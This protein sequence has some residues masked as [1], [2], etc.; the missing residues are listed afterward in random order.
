MSTLLALAERIEQSPIG[1]AIA[2]SRYAFPVIEGVH[3]IGLSISVGLIFLTDLR[4]TG[5][6]F[7]QIPVRDV[8]HHLRPY[9]VAGFAL[10]F[11]SGGLLFWSEA[12]MLVESPAFPFKLLFMAL[13]GANALYFE[14]VLAKQSAVQE[15]RPLLPRN[16]KLAG[17]ASLFLWT[18]VIICG[19]LIPYLPRWT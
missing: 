3:L 7:G 17:A 10:V 18:L 13:A 11:L 2:E 1:A 14:L 5:V 16:V 4:L 9:V 19:R 6:L 15:D 8:I 12:S